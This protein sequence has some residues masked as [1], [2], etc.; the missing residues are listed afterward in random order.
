MSNVSK[1]NIDSSKSH[2][3]VGA[4]KAT[5]NRGLQPAMDHILE[6][7]SQP[8]PSVENVSE[9]SAPAS[10]AMDVDEDEEDAEALRSL[11]GVTANVVEAKVHIIHTISLYRTEWCLLMDSR[12]SSAQSVAKFSRTRLSLNSTLRRVATTNSRNLQRRYVRMMTYS[13]DLHATHSYFKVKPLT[14]EEKKERLA[15]LRAK[16]AEKRSR[17]TIE[18]AAEQKANEQLR[19]KAGKV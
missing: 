4:L 7:E 1:L 8:V 12:V 2:F 14:E 18:E 9:S 3:L 11:G 5:G 17:K 15:E 10:S 6:N 16:M 13:L 19:R